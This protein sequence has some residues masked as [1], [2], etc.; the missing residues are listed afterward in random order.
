MLATTKGR[1]SFFNIGKTSS[2]LINMREQ[3][4][5]KQKQVS[6]KS[7]VVASDLSVVDDSEFVKF[8]NW[9]HA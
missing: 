8:R 7:E 4:A 2:S 6:D 9:K 1:I 3:K 5:V